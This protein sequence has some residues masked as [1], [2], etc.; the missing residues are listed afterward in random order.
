MNGYKIGE[1][2]RRTGVPVETIRYYERCGLIPTVPRATN[3][4]RSY[5]EV[6]AARLVMIRRAKELGFSL[7]EIGELLSMF[8]H[9]DTPCRHLHCRLI[10]KIDD[11]EGRIAELHRLKSELQTLA[12]DCAPNTPISHCPVLAAIAPV[13]TIASLLVTPIKES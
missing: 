11:L 4:Y 3:G 8:D 6:T 7:S 12:A 2:A 10:G 13:G 1:L 5:P 9:R